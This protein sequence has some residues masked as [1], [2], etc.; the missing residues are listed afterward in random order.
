MMGSCLRS[1]LTPRRIG[2]LNSKPDPEQDHRRRDARAHNIA[3]EQAR[4]RVLENIQQVTYSIR[5]HARV[6]WYLF[7]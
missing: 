6:V 3:D 1:S 4:H 2:G 5:K 7:V